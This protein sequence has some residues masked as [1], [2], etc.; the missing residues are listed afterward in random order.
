MLDVNRLSFDQARVILDGCARRSRQMGFPM[1]SAVTDES[2]HLIA[3][4]VDKAFTGAVA[5]KGTHVYNELCQPGKR[6]VGIHITNGGRFSI[7]GGGLPLTAEGGIIGGVG[8]SSGAAV[9]DQAV[10]EAALVYFYEKTG[11]KP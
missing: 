7:I 6:T 5:R 8:V 11:S 9:E 1:C 2:G 4:A 10:A 3:L